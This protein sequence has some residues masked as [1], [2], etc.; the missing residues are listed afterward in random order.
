ME[1]DWQRDLERWLEPY[2]EDL[3]DVTPGFH[4]AGT[5]D[6]V[7]LELPPD[8]GPS[9]RS[10]SSVPTSGQAHVPLTR[11]AAISAVVADRLSMSIGVQTGPRI[12]AQ[13]GV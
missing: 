13:K 10:R 7:L 5:R 4:P 3:G 11:R 9:G 8:P 1:E 2:L 12:G 6:R